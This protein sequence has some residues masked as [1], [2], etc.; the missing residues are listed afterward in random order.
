MKLWKKMIL[1]ILANV[2]LTA[3]AVFGYAYTV[4]NTT[5]KTLETTYDNLGQEDDGV[6]EIKQTKPLTILLMGIDTGGA[7]RENPW[8][9]RSDT[10][11]LATVNPVTNQTTMASLE[12][13][14]Y[15]NLVNTEGNNAGNDKLNSAYAYYGPL[16]TI[17]TIQQLTDIHIDNYLMIN[18]EGVEDLVNAVGG[19]DVNNTTVGFNGKPIT[20]SIEETEPAYTATIEPG[21]QHV[22]GEQALVYARMR[23]QDPEGDIGRQQRQREVITALVKKMLTMDNMSKYIDILDA[24][25]D[26][27]KTNLQINAQ[28][29]SSLLGYRDAFNTMNS[30]KFEGLG[31][32]I[33]GASVQ[34]M[35][36]QN[37]LA[38]DNYMK[39]SLGESTI[40]NLNENVTTL[41]NL[42][43]GT[44]S[45]RIYPTVTVTKTG[46]QP[47]TYYINED[48][49]TTPVENASTDESSESTVDTGNSTDV[50]ASSE[51]TTTDDGQW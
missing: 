27:I 3:G 28:T 44:G 24:V 36:E 45:S 40:E 37:L 8:E 35:P 32:M 31:D 11:I 14:M 21:V 39:L 29:I 46:Q 10:M 33:N 34:V 42:G 2:L 26:K 16:A 13:D 41:Q 38:V 25:K 48:G 22:N 50:E 18:M 47:I 20:I 6:D 1:I 7:G 19:I 15:A 17:N 5:E 4:L 51:D 12:R 23:H 49:S 9:G 30:V 43:R